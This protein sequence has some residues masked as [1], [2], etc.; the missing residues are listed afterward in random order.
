MSAT[1]TQKSEQTRQRL[2]EV[3]M[4][5][6]LDQGFDKTTMREIARAAG[7]APGAAYYYFPSKE[8]L[9]FGFYEQSFEDQLPLAEKVLREAKGL[10]ERLAGVVT[11]HLKV[12]EP[13]HE[14]SKVLFR[15][16]AD[17]SQPISPFS[18]ES[19]PLRQRNI[20][21]MARAL[22]GDKLAPELVRDLPELLWLYKMGVILY[23]LHDSSP[24]HAKTYKLIQRSAALIAQLV[25]LAKLP[26]IRG[27]AL[28]AL[29]FFKEFK[30]Y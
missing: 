10:E 23:W 20:E 27:F 14:L 26:V 28:R 15:V 3:S 8:A 19:G 5:L 18:K 22:E 30:N 24:R 4:K 2:V 16:A 21:L 12:S 17:P 13:Y 9:I 11:A 7:L 6:F 25:K 29:S 1:K